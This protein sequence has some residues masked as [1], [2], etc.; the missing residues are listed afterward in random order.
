[1]TKSHQKVQTLLSVRCEMGLYTS[2]V[3]SV[4]RMFN[5][6]WHEYWAI[7]ERGCFNICS[8][9]LQMEQSVVLQRQQLLT[10]T[11][12]VVMPHLHCPYCFIVTFF[13]VERRLGKSHPSHISFLIEKK[14]GG[15][16]KKQNK[17]S[18][19]KYQRKSNRYKIWQV[20]R[21]QVW[22]SKKHSLLYVMQ[23]KP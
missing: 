18:S 1:M 7:A 22:L 9:T 5:M 12:R 23:S 13:W 8:S 6:K 16:D 10:Q 17:T 4:F 14:M 15:G 3:D 2:N 11:H 20:D 19:P 21:L